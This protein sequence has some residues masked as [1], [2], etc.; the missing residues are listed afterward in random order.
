VIYKKGVDNSTTDTLSRRPHYAEFCAL[1][2][3]SSAWLQEV[4]DGYQQ[5]T[6]SLELLAAL[7][8]AER[9]LQFEQWC[10]QI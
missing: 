9:P 7:T 1:S 5:D 4:V 8:I 6:S 3:G 10:Y 2:V